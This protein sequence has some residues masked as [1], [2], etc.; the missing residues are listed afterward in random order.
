MLE[1][2]KLTQDPH[3]CPNQHQKLTTSPMPT[4]FGRR[5]LM[6]SRVILLTERQTDKHTE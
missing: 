2:E 6:R 5:T 1:N 3:L 4:V